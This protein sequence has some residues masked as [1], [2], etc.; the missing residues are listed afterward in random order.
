VVLNLCMKAEM[1][2]ARFAA[3]PH[4]PDAEFASVAIFKEL[5]NQNNKPEPSTQVVS[6]SCTKVLATTSLLDYVRLGLV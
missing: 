1:S 6:R 3:P 2:G 4:A 5:R